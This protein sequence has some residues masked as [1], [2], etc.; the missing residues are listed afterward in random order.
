MTPEERQA[1]LTAEL[2]AYNADITRA[3]QA[4]AE[5]NALPNATQVELRSLLTLEEYIQLKLNELAQQGANKARAEAK[6]NLQLQTE[7]DA[8]SAQLEAVEAD[9]LVIEAAR[10][11][12][13][14][15]LATMT[16]KRDG[17]LTDKAAL[18]TQVETLT[19][20]KQTVTTDLATANATIAT[21]TQQV[22]DQTALAT[23]KSTQ[24]ETLTESVLDVQ[25]EVSGLE[26][27]RQTHLTKI[28]FLESIRTYDPNQ[29]KSE[30]FYDRITKDEIFALGTLSATDETAKGILELLG[31]YK[32]N[33]WQVLLNDPQV[34]G[35]LQ[36][37]TALGTLVEGRVA[38]ITQ[39]A[40]REEA[41]IES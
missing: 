23:E 34:V 38:Q 30:S 7:Y 28:S 21:L 41:Y 37:L 40:S 29:I 14:S 26:S 5:H 31:A 25:E 39:P 8:M 27:E 19:T 22:A 1:G 11:Q 3:N 33:K 32:A 9:K 2:T 24:V 35:A 10:V 4:I 16:A 6:T 15:D 18:T 20:E 36:Y 13:V 12:A 17:L